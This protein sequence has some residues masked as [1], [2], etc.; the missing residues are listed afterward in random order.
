MHNKKKL[1]FLNLESNYSN[2]GTIRK[3]IAQLNSLSELFEVE[4]VIHKNI[5]RNRWI[6]GLYFYLIYPI[7]VY[8]KTRIN[9]GS[10]IYYRYYPNCF[11]L[12]II[13]LCIRNSHH[14]YVE[15]NTK[16]RYEFK[17]NI[18]LKI[19]YMNLLSEQLIYK[20]AHTVLVITP[21]VGDYVREI[22][23]YCSI[24]VM[25]NGYDPAEIDPNSDNTFQISHEELEKAIALGNGQKK[26]I[27]VGGVYYWDGL[28]RIIDIISQLENTCLYLVGDLERIKQLG[29]TRESL[30][31]KQVF[32]LGERNLCELEFLYSKCDFGL[33]SFGQD[34]KNM[35]QNPTL[36]VREYLYFGLP[37]IMGHSDPQINGAD[38]IYTYRDLESLRQ[39]IER[40]FDRDK[41]QQYAKE[42]LSWRTIMKNVFRSE[43]SGSI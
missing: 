29:I 7:Y 32:L 1:L 18:S 31:S 39:F 43:L 38:F 9:K 10:I 36:K 14:I 21:E 33:G 24:Q 4:H 11:L 27:W 2:L 37:V 35:T 30:P 22:E 8:R 6:R 5:S 25:G 41:I 19:Y 13:L 26:I 17:K 42:N 16:H 28:D 40:P 23:P 3:A 12:N 34:R 20:S 15:V